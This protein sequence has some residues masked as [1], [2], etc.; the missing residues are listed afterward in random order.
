[1]GDPPH[2]RA[3]VF[4]H[5]AVKERRC[6]PGA[7]IFQNL[8]FGCAH[9]VD[10]IR[11]HQYAIVGD[12]HGD[13][14]HMK[15]G[16]TRRPLSDRDLHQVVRADLSFFQKLGM[17]LGIRHPVG[18]GL[19]KHQ[20]F[21]STP[22]PVFI[23]LLRHQLRES[24]VAGIGKGCSQVLLTMV[25]II[26]AEQLNTVDDLEGRTGRID[27][28][29]GAVYKRRPALVR[30]QIF[31]GRLH[32]LRFE[33]GHG[34]HGQDLSCRGLRDHDSSPVVPSPQCFAGILLKLC[35][36]RQIDIITR[37]QG[38]FFVV[39]DPA[40]KGNVRGEHFIFKELFDPA[41][42]IYIKAHSMAE[43]F[44]E[45]VIAVI[46][47]VGISQRLTVS[48]NDTPSA[49]S[50][51]QQLEP[52]VVTIAK[53][54]SFVHDCIPA[55]RNRHNGKQENKRH[56]SKLDLVPRSRSEALHMHF[57]CLRVVPACIGSIRNSDTALNRI[58]CFFLQH[59]LNSV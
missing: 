15:G 58:L 16:D 39:F 59:S 21:E 1:M 44:P 43:I 8:I 2:Q 33:P 26:K 22:E 14:I 34:N 56:R 20:L 11:A 10:H 25:L 29:G 18:K 17:A 13:H 45:R 36:Q 55:E 5:T 9:A 27:S 53:Q 40:L 57:P 54:F 38:E 4:R 49:V 6:L 7:V 31:P 32:F 3:Q 51:L 23:E 47:I 28:L 12:G 46:V 19:V 52:L 30:T 42:A 35:V 50:F 48:G 24:T 41:A 37:I